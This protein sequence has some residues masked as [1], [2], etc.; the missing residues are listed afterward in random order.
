MTEPSADTQGCRDGYTC[1]WGRG[2]DDPSGFCDVG[3]FTDVTE[4]NIGAECETDDECYSPFGYGGCDPD[5]GCTVFECGAPGVPADICGSGATCVDFIDFGVDL[6]ACLRTCA[7]ADDC[8]VGDACA[9]LDE[10]PMTPG[11]QVCFGFCL[12]SAECRDGEVCD[13]NNQCVAP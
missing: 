2:E 11:D 3:V 8:P 9:D 7:T 1:Y 13:V 12:N 6:F 4:S 10:D 5:F